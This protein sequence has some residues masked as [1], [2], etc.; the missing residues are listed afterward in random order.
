MLAQGIRFLGRY[1][2]SYYRNVPPELLQLPEAPAGLADDLQSLEQLFEGPH[3]F[4]VPGSTLLETLL[5]PLRAEAKEQQAE[6]ERRAKAAREAAEQAG[7][8]N[9][10]AGWAFAAH[11]AQAAAGQGAGQ[12]EDEVTGKADHQEAA[13]EQKKAAGL[14]DRSQQVFAEGGA[15]VCMHH[16]EYMFGRVWFNADGRCIA[17]ACYTYATPEHFAEIFVGPSPV[18]QLE[19]PPADADPG[20]WANWAAGLPPAYL[21]SQLHDELRAKQLHT[22]RVLAAAGMLSEDLL[23]RDSFGT[24]LSVCFRNEDAGQAAVATAPPFLAELL[25]LLDEHGVLRAYA[26]RDREVSTI[27]QGMISTAQTKVAAILAGEELKDEEGK[28]EEND[29]GGGAGGGQPVA[30]GPSME[31]YIIKQHVCLLATD[32]V[33]PR[34]WLAARLLRA[35]DGADATNNI[36]P[37]CGSFV[38]LSTLMQV[39]ER[40]E[41]AGEVIEQLLA[42][43]ANPLL[44]LP[45]PLGWTALAFAAKAGNGAAVERLLAVTPPEVVGA[46]LVLDFDQASRLL[47]GSVSR[48]DGSGGPMFLGGDPLPPVAEEIR[49]SFA[50]VAALPRGSLVDVTIL[51]ASRALSSE[52][53]SLRWVLESKMRSKVPEVRTEYPGGFVSVT[54][55][56]VPEDAYHDELVAAM[57]KRFASVEVG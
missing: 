47:D 9:G 15:M 29:E 18:C 44:R 5:P 24:A 34:P 35:L 42:A 57:E 43:G 12:A 7:G 11:A 23:P 10:G 48:V 41:A 21:C 52:A 13:G 53:S 45:A 27:V 22:V 38:G 40:P 3:C 51:N 8:A 4:F 30:K 26:A 25:D 31:S 36:S 49:A 54:H 19:R 2:W 20:V 28:A 17:M 32:M 55:A 56:P 6:D 16:Q 46:E 39:A 50:K 37:E 33:V 14:R 1:S